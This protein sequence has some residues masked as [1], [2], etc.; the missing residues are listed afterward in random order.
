MSTTETGALRRLS[1][2]TRP[3]ERI[4]HLGIGA[5]G[6]SHQ[7]WYT[8]RAA[9]A[10]DW[11]IVGYTGRRPDLAEAL[12]RQDGLFTLLTRSDAED[13][14]EIV[15]SVVTAHPGADTAAFVR[16]LADPH[17]A[18]VTLT[19]TEAAYRVDGP[20][21]APSDLAHDLGLL[22]GA[23]AARAGAD[24][25]ALRTPLARLLLGLE[26]RRRADAGP[27][28]LVPCDNLPGNGAVLSDA[29]A[30]L[31]ERSLP[32]LLSFLEESVSFVS[33]SVDRITP[34]IDPAA[35][36]RAAELSG[37]AD[38]VPVL[39][40][41]FADWR[42]AGEFPGGRPDWESAGAQPVDD[43]E[44]YE[45]RK[46]WL[47]NG[48]H[49]LMAYAGIAR[50]HRTVADAADDAVIAGWVEELWD[51]ACAHLPASADLQLA[52]YRTRL[53]E[54]FRNRAMQDELTR[55]GAEG[56]TKL[57][58]RIAPVLRAERAAG[59]RGT[60]SARAVALWARGAMRGELPPDSEQ[61]RIRAALEDAPTMRAVVSVVDPQL[62]DD[63]ALVSDILRLADD[64]L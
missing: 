53:Q 1:R 50:G 3:P 21:G 64:A 63:A 54:R 52:E 37:F 7:A 45:L 48:A 14:A 39:A 12:S 58:A 18:L 15:G 38:E 34:R 4:A 40:E 31:S 13:R 42:L 28:A 5:F 10:A 16:Q 17:T 9:D 11:G 60:G 41:P 20:D 47:L 61:A 35:A 32:P 8:A 46:L 36:L 43:I 51:E 26:H 56:V 19:V 59:R 22:P 29:L 6:R 33:S 23:A 44:P 25:P 57:N 27:I 49:T 30:R 2:D 24:L 62:A 55:I